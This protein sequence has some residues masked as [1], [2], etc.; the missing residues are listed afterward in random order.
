MRLRNQ[1]DP[2]KIS[3]TWGRAMKLKIRMCLGSAAFA[4]AL[5]A[6]PFSG[7][8]QKAAPVSQTRF[9]YD[10]SHE[11]QIQ[12]TVVSFT[13]SSPVAPIGPH[14]TIQ[15]SS[16]IVDVHLGNADTMKAN[17]IFVEPGDSVKIVGA[18]QNYGNANVFLARVLVK[19]N[20]TVALRNRNG[21]P[22]MPRHGAAVKTQSILGGAQ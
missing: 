1:R 7:A 20:Q 5:F 17:D 9:S 13:A 4:G 3:R 8:Q 11:T 21:I 12:G 10:M 2:S 16:G 6:A 15:T 14:A 22:I 19:G 18:N